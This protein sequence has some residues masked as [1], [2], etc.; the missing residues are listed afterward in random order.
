MNEKT[1]RV[2]TI[3]RSAI[4]NWSA[5]SGHRDAYVRHS[6]ARRDLAEQMRRYCKLYGR[7]GFLDRLESSLREHS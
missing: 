6:Q 1:K 2:F 5:R 3:L 4:D 7:R